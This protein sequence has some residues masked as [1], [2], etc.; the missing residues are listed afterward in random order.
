MIGL[1]FD[2]PTEN[3]FS[4]LN[5]DFLVLRWVYFYAEI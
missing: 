2:Y 4:G 3:S 5:S 1:D